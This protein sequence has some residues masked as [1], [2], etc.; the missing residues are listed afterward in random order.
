MRHNPRQGVLLPALGTLAL[1]LS[2]LCLNQGATASG[3]LAAEAG[4]VP[5]QWTITYDGKPVMVYVFDPRK[6]KPYVQVLNTLDG[7]GVLRDAPE[8]H[9]HHHG[10]MYGLKVNGINFWEETAG[11]GVE[12]V[13]ETSPPEILNSMV[14]MP[15]ARLVQVLHWLAPED[16]FLP[17]SIALPL[18]VERRVLTLTLDTGKRET[19]L[20][21]QSEFEVG[22]KT[23]VV[24]LT[25]ANY[26]GLGMRFL[27]ELDPLAVHL[28]PDGLPDLADR[29]QIV[30]AFPWEAVVFDLQGKP[31]TIAVFGAPGNA[32]G[33]P[34]Y[35]AMKTPFAYLSATQGLDREPLVYRTGEHFELNYLVALYP[36]LKPAAILAERG[37][38]WISSSH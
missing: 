28:T 25:G 11:C 14:R 10:L 20:H 26:H 2:C 9:L 27:K 15:Q 35:F 12:K 22:S 13:V 17:N 24:I 19:A 33:E 8:D 18:L 7:Y 16:A 36:G 6:F 38:Q 32:R 1:G 23:N 5:T 30:S 29:K 37:R 3:R 31:A 21:W 34:R 4:S